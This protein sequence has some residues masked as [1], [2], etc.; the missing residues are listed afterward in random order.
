MTDSSLDPEDISEFY[1]NCAKA[2]YDW[3]DP[4]QIDYRADV[5]A[6][7]GSIITHVPVLYRKSPHLPPYELSRVMRPLVQ[8][9]GFFRNL[10]YLQ[11][12]VPEESKRQQN[13]FLNT[14]CNVALKHE[15]ERGMVDHF[16]SYAFSGALHDLVQ[17]AEKA[18]EEFFPEALSG[19]LRVAKRTDNVDVY[20]LVLKRHR[21]KENG[22]A[23]GK[24]LR[25]SGWTR[26]VSG[27]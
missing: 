9:D 10:S 5:A 25:N 4:F 11:Q 24:A 26:G 19:L 20:Q 21:S 18:Y 17:I 3:N 14:L 22:P 16:F 23:I 8:M 12:T 27:R 7:K 13:N 1:Q 15:E 2:L 6:I